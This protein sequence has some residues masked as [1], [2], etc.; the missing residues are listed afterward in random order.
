VSNRCIC[1]HFRPTSNQLQRVPATPFKI[2]TPGSERVDF[3]ATHS[4]RHPNPCL[5]RPSRI[6]AQFVAR[7]TTA[8]YG[9]ATTDIALERLTTLPG[10]SRKLDEYKISAICPSSKIRRPARWTNTSKKSGIGAFPSRPLGYPGIEP[11][12]KQRVWDRNYA[13]D[14]RK[15][16][17]RQVR[18]LI[19]I[20][21]QG[22]HLD[23][24]QLGP[25]CGFS[26]C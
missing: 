4:H 14:Q 17:A 10:A 3:L 19:N 9:P 6:Q 26:S 16:A 8:D 23:C 21:K 24:C 5:A 20:A 1:D 25:L 2:E 7:N 18:D 15:R 13:E 22:E 12:A 11:L